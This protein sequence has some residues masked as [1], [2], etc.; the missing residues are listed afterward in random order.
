MDVHKVD[1][2]FVIAGQV[3]VSVPGDLCFKCMGL[4]QPDVLAKEAYEVAG[5]NPQVVWS[6]GVLAS[7]AIGVLIEMVTPWFKQSIGSTLLQYDGNQQTVAVNTW[8]EHIRDR[9]CPHFAAGD[10]GAKAVAVRDTL[11]LRRCS[12]ESRARQA[13]LAGHSLPTS[14]SA[15][16]DAPPELRSDSSF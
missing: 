13:T 6:N 11:H 15:T 1:D 5:G 4:I 14:R 3:S 10:V 7:I 16:P 9:Q 8:V 2:H 12:Q